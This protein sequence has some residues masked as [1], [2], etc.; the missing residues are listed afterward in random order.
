MTR[1]YKTQLGNV[2][3]GFWLSMAGYPRT[4]LHKFDIV[5]TDK[6]ANTFKTHRDT[7]VQLRPKN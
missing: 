4:D 2:Y 5:T 7:G 3:S 6:A 1:T